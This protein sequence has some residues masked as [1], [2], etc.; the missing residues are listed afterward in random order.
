MAKMKNL[1]IFKLRN[2]NKLRIQCSNSKVIQINLIDLIDKGFKFSLVWIFYYHFFSFSTI[3]NSQSDLLFNVR[4]S[5]LLR[6]LMYAVRYSNSLVSIYKSQTKL[7]E[8]AE[9]L[10]TVFM[11]QLA[12]RY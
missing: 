7:D 12:E 9:Q 10:H 2:I 3:F 1:N 6:N 4:T 11:Y 8:E 5:R